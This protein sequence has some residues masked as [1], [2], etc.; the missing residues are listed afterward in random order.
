MYANAGSC[1]IGLSPKHSF[2]TGKI[3]LNGFDVFIKKIEKPIII[4]CWNKS[5]KILYC[6]GW[7]LDFNKNK[8]INN[9]NT[10]N[11]NNKLPSWFPQVPEIL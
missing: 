6:F 4:I 11:H 9:V 10:S 7:S 8:K 2:G 3:K 1:K 5:V